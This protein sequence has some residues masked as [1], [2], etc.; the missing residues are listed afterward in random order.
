MLPAPYHLSPFISF[1]SAR[2]ISDEAQGLN[3]AEISQ[4]LFD[5]QQGFPA[6]VLGF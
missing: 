2:V 6:K 5:L 4:S 1:G 3:P